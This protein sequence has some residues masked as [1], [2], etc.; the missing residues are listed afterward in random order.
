MNRPAPVTEK[1]HDFGAM[2][3]PEFEHDNCG[4]GLIAHMDGVPSNGLVETAIESLNRMTHRGATAADGK[5]GDGCGLLMKQPKGFMQAIAAEQGYTLNQNHAVGMVFLNQD[6]EKAAS[7]RSLLEQNLSAQGLEVLGWRIVPVD[8]ENGCGDH[9]LAILPQIEQIFVNAPTDMDE[10]HLER[11]L[12][13]ARRQTEKVVEPEDEFFYIPSLSARVISYKGLVMPE[14]LPI[15]YKDLKDK[16]F[17]SALCVYHQRFATNTLPQWR[18][19]QPF[20]QL[21]HNGEINTVQGNRNWSVARAMKFKTPLIPDMDA[22]RPLVSMSGSDSS[23][24]DN[25]LEALLMGGMDIFRAMRL[26][27]PP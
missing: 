20:R 25:M 3:R 6:E 15:F 2:Y 22:V 17:E 10:I 11:A 1:N 8:A 13:I 16:R 14:Y 19:A 4:F 7:A 26:L 21:A 23:S 5:S 9:A 27:I 18:L 12:F 24:L